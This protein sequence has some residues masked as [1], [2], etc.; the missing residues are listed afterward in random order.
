MPFLTITFPVFDPATGLPR[1]SLYDA[2][3]ENGT[4]AVI[5]SYSD[6]RDVGGLKIPHKIS[7]TFSGRKF[8]DLTIT[9]L[10]FNVGLKQE[11]L[12]KRP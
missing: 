8:Q 9:S 12:G 6:F 11:D 2:P 3:I 7:V 4:V 5:E 1:N 10:K